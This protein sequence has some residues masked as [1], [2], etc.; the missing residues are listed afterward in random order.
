VGDQVSHTYRKTADKI[1]V[2]YVV[3]FYVLGQQNRRQEVL[4]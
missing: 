3:I 2:L 4:D 1:I